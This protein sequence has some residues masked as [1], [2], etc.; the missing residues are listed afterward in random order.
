MKVVLTLLVCFMLATN[1]GATTPYHDHHAISETQLGDDFGMIEVGNGDTLYA[2]NPGPPRRVYRSVD[3]GGSWAVVKTFT[4][5][6]GG[7]RG[8]FVDASGRVYIG[9]VE[10]GI[11]HRGLV[12]GDSL[13]FTDVLTMQ[14]DT[15]QGSW[16]N[17]AQADAGTL[18]VGNY[19]GTLNEHCA[20]IYRSS[21]G[22][23]WTEV[24]HTPDINRHIH[25][26]G[27][28]PWSDEVYASI[29]D[30]PLATAR[31]VHSADNG[32]TWDTVRVGTPL[33]KPTS[34]A[35][36]PTRR[37]WGSDVG[38]AGTAIDSTN[39]I[40]WTDDDSAYTQGLRLED[41]ENNYVWDIATNDV[42]TLFA[43]T[44]GKQASGNDIRMY[45]S[46]DSGGSWYTVKEFG[47]EGTWQGVQHISREADPD[48]YSYYCVTQDGGSGY[49][50]F[51]FT[52]VSV[53]TVGS[54]GDFADVATALGDFRVGA[55]DTLIMLENGGAAHVIEDDAMLANM[56]VRG[57]TQ[58]ASLYLVTNGAADASG[59]IVGSGITATFKDLTFRTLT[60]IT[61]AGKTMIEVTD[62]GQ[63]TVTRCA[64]RNCDAETAPGISLTGTGEGTTTATL[65]DCIVDSCSGD[66]AVGTTSGFLFA[67]D[68]DAIVID[69]L[70]ATNNWSAARGGAVHVSNNFDDALVK[71]SLF[72]NNRS[73]DDGAA[74]YLDGQGTAAPLLLKVWHCTFSG[75]SSEWRAGAICMFDGGTVQECVIAN[76]LAERSG[77][78]IHCGTP[79][80]GSSTAIINCVITENESYETGGGIAC[81]DTTAISIVGCTISGNTAWGGGGAISATGGA[82]PIVENSILAFSHA[83]GSVFCDSTSSASLACT[84]VFGNEE[85]DWTECIA[86]QEFT[87]G[88]FSL[89]PLFCGMAGGD[90]SLCANSPCLPVLR[91]C[92]ELIGALGQGCDD[93]NSPVEGALF[94]TS[95]DEET[96][97]LRWTLPGLDGYAGLNIY[98]ATE[99]D[100]DFTRLNGE[101]LPASLPGSYIDSTVW[102]GTTFRYQLRAVRPDGTEEDAGES[103]SVTTPG[104]LTAVLRAPNPNPFSDRCVFELDLPS[105]SKRAAIGVFNVAGR[106]VKRLHDGPLTRGRHG[107]AWNGL[108]TDGSQ[109]A[110]GVYFVRCESGDLVLRQRTVLLR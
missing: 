52:D 75:N 50:S 102:P 3:D 48:G 34:L 24:Y 27:V 100:G 85:G 65:T 105:S 54:G 4:R 92:E 23:H 98:R 46:W 67:D 22:A 56:T 109:C 28:D 45:A 38:E 68:A 63:I 15:G 5:D 39:V 26:V 90:F 31:I 16:W 10:T 86:D 106:C 99:D 77:G 59:F 80:E 11:V 62:G 94:V 57:A 69:G 13:A 107:F 78:G 35:F 36:T 88:N 84:D 91:D 19:A 66:S 14:C 70:V 58:D 18:F 74:V 73:T 9:L 43:G 40:E 53:W 83:G 97:T 30:I 7:F 55:A 93:C 101:L 81:V 79:H 76:N 6:C 37:I 87:G 110:A 95:C 42:R 1:I 12:S 21:T 60:E 32:A 2:V 51:R 25:E 72:V 71:N 47:C 17:M 44:V 33:C 41:D 49:N 8:L 103:V 82:H 29:G 20:A 104:R 89:D 61:T 64:F 96:V 108:D